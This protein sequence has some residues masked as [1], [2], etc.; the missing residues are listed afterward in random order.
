MLVT[1]IV[2]G[3]AKYSEQHIQKSDTD[4]LSLDEIKF[5]FIYLDRKSNELLV[6]G[7][8]DY[9]SGAYLEVIATI[10]ERRFY[11]VTNGSSF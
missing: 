3:V 4:L 7:N 5:I 11:H 8:F 1:V 9:N 2:C 6:W 10:F